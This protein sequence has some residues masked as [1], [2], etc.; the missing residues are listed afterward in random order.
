MVVASTMFPHKQIYKGAC[1]SPD[2]RVWNKIDNV[3]IDARHKSDTLDVR[4]L[5][6]SNIRSD[7]HYVCGPN[8]DQKSQRHWKNQK[9]SKQ[10][11]V[12]ARRIAEVDGNCSKFL[13]IKILLLF[14]FHVLVTQLKYR[15]LNCS[16]ERSLQILQWV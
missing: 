10:P 7:Y 8:I 15:L 16:T 12:I 9:H 13:Y 11:K 4:T 2:R 6:D 14:L 5:R 3:L 1:K